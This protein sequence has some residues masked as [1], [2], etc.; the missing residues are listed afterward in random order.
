MQAGGIKPSRAKCAL[1]LSP[2]TPV[3]ALAGRGSFLVGVGSAGYRGVEMNG[4]SNPLKSFGLC[5]Y[6]QP[7]VPFDLIDTV[8]CHSAEFVL[9]SVMSSR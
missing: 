8:F 3:T 5:V 9:T 2:K 6:V 4:L 7:E 1:T